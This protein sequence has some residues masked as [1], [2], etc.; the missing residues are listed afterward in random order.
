MTRLATE[1]VESSPQPERPSRFASLR[2]PQAITLY[3]YLGLAIYVTC[4]LWADPAG[5]RQVGDPQDVNQATWFVRYAANAVEHF[6]LPALITSA[7]NAPNTV[8]LMWNTSLL[9]PG[10]LVAPVTLL[11]GPQVA[12]TTLL[13]LAVRGR[14]PP[15]SMCCATGMSASCRRRSAAPSM[16]SRRPW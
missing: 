1:Q 5:L 7:M 6:R 15:C 16:A 2:S 3:C 4:R 9:L 14:P 8:N 10:V 11:F 13:A 12:L